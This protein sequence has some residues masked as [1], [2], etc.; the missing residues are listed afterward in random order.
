M[1]SRK[2]S[3]VRDDDVAMRLGFYIHDT[4]R[5]RKLVYDAVFRPAEVTRAQASV[6]SYLWEQDSLTQLELAARLDLGKV[7]L[8]ALIDKLEISRS[9]IAARSAMR[10]RCT[11]QGTMTEPV[12]S[13]MRLA[14]AARRER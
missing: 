8:G 3:K 14:E 12:A 10:W 1:T 2:T 7:A 6:L 11:C 4:S 9:S 13:L 5:L